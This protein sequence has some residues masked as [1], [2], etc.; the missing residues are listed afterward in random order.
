[1]EKPSERT[2]RYYDYFDI[3]MYLKEEYGFNM[4]DRDT[5][6]GYD[7]YKNSFWL[8]VICQAHGM[9]NGSYITIYKYM[10]D[11]KSEYIKKIGALLFHRF[12]DKN[13][14]ITLYVGW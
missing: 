6:E 5:G 3:E 13:D 1:M 7:K 10:L 9:S 12:G 4:D 14:E 8:E 2:L 11:N